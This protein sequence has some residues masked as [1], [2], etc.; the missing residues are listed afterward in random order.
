MALTIQMMRNHISNLLLDYNIHTGDA[1]LCLRMTGAD[2]K[3]AKGMANFEHRHVFFLPIDSDRDYYGAL[4]EIGHIVTNDTAH[5]DTYSQ[6]LRRAIY[7]ANQIDDKEKREIGIQLLTELRL[8][9]EQAAMDW[10]RQNAL[11]WTDAMTDYAVESYATH[12][13][14]LY[15]PIFGILIQIS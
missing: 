8:T 11:E 12:L 7:V 13:Q 1:A 5:F 10:A 2:L 15:K 3:L 4:H 9:C 6:I 14:A